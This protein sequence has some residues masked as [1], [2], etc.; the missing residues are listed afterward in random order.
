MMATIPALAVGALLHERATASAIWPT[1]AT[2]SAGCAGCS[3]MPVVFR[4]ASPLAGSHPASSAAEDR[5]LASVTV[6]PSSR[7]SA[8]TVV[9]TVSAE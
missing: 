7:P 9:S 6:T 2:A 8:R 4:T 3:A 1:R 5:P